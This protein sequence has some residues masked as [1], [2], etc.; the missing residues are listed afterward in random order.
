M[1]P[2]SA[3]AL[4]I[5]PLCASA[6]DLR[7]QEPVA[8]DTTV[9]VVGGDWHRDN[10]TGIYRVIV[11]TAGFEHV[12]SSIRLEWLQQRDGSSAVVIAADSMLPIPD[13]MYSLGLP[14]LVANFEGW[15]IS[16][17][18]THT[19]AGSNACWLIWLGPPGKVALV[20]G[21]D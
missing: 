17:C 19:Y 18:G 21:P 4:L 14:Q 7:C 5:L 2:K 10:D 15:N 1:F 13:R 6:T 16:V 9:V 20:R 8:F 12:A 11:R 3:L